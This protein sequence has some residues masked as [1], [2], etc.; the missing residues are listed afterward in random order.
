MRAQKRSGLNRTVDRQP[1]RRMIES[2]LGP[3]FAVGVSSVKMSSIYMYVAR[4]IL[5]AVFLYI[6]TSSKYYRIPACPSNGQSTGC[7]RMLLYSAKQD[8]RI[9]HSCNSFYRRSVYNGPR[10]VEAIACNRRNHV[11]REFDAGMQE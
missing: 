6:E 1:L 11:A 9:P 8:Q 3:Q 4:V 7:C 10:D 5:I 2:V